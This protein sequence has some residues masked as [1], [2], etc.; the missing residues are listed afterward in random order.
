MEALHLIAIF[1]FSYLLLKL[2]FLAPKAKHKAKLPP[3]PPSLPIIGHL[4]LLKKP[5]H[6]SISLLAARYGPILYLRLGYRPTLVIS[7]P[8]LVEECFTT[9]DVAL[10]NRPNFPSVKELSNNYSN[11]IF[12]NYGPS[13]RHL[14]KTVTVQI[15]SNHRLLLSTSARN[16]EARYLVHRLFVGS[17]A[18]K[19]A[20]NKVNIKV[21]AFEFVL[22][23]VMGMIAGKR[24]YGEEAKDWEE[25]RRFR[26]MI[27][28]FFALA[29]GST[30]M[31]FFPWLRLVDSI[32]SHR[33]LKLLVKKR[34]EFSQR[35][36]DEIRKGIDAQKKKTMIGDLLGLQDREP[37]GYNDDLIRSLS[38]ILLQAG[39][40]SS[41]N[42]I[43]WA[44]SHLLNNPHVLAKAQH[45]IQMVVGRERL[46]EESDVPSLPY[47]Q[48]IINETLRLH[49]AAPLNVP[50]ESAAECII[51]GYKIPIGTTLLINIYAIHRDPSIWKDPTEFKPERFEN[52][53]AEG[54][55]LLP[56]GMGR[57]KCPGEGLALKM[58]ALAL[59]TLIQCFEWERI[60]AKEVDMTESS[61]IVVPKA[62]R[63]DTMYRPRPDMI[64]L[65][66]GL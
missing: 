9:N 23:I 1:L 8:Q 22:N 58:I 42:T 36:I 16:Y 62:V 55:W 51:G 34:N 15:L 25:A 13:W 33:R 59:G 37:G 3:S 54:M 29:P 26:Q 28:E 40:E 53:K 24:Y 19:S 57:R 44:M 38:L 32:S 47:L 41:S 45:E 35:L 66:S 39:T 14:R 30:L 46:V 50:H 52:G 17:A 56:F 60:G 63:L 43:E 11:L 48:A 18:D 5:L 6:H 61:G 20:F 49:P 27:E 31:D 2:F 10:A 21:I 7:S 4:H 65:L 64:P 12:S